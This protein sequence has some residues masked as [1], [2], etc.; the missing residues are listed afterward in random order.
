MALKIE[1]SLKQV[2]SRRFGIQAREAA[3]RKSLDE[4]R[5]TRPTSHNAV[6]V[7]SNGS[8]Y[9]GA[10]N[11]GKNIMIDANKR[12]TTENTCFKCGGKGHYAFQCPNKNLHIGCEKEGQVEDDGGLGEEEYTG[13]EHEEDDSNLVGVVRRI[14]ASSKEEKK[15]D[16]L[17]TAIFLTF[18]LSGNKLCKLI[19][20]GGSSMNVVSV[21]TVERLNLFTQPHPQ[22]YKTAWLNKMTLQVKQRALVSISYGSYVDDIWCDIVPM[23]VI[24]ILLGQP[25]LYDRNVYHSRKENTYYF[26]FNGKKL[27]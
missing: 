3:T 23:N 1:K 2:N 7:R 22:P 18:V 16:W 9:Q 21:A 8:K 5:V 6:L 27:L 19:I 15:E 25:W 4:G 10:D 12:G 14:L 20:D 24:H 26:L 11:K 17:R 13:S